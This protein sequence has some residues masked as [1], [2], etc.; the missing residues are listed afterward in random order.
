MPTLTKES[1]LQ[2]AFFDY[3]FREDVGFVCIAHSEPHNKASFAQKFFEWPKD[4]N[5][6]VKLIREVRP[7]H[8]VWFCVNLL[9][10]RERKK[11][12]CM[13]TNLVWADLDT[14]DPEVVQPP[15]QCVILSSPS[16][17]QAIWRLNEYIDPAEAEQFSKILAYTYKQDGADPSGWDLTQLLRIPYTFNHKYSIGQIP[18]QVKLVQSYESLMPKALMDILPVPDNM[19]RSETADATEVPGNLPELEEILFKYGGRFLEYRFTD[20]YNYVPHK[21]DDWSAKLWH[22]I[23]VCLE[24]GLDVEEAFVVAKSSNV[25]KYERDKRPEVYLWKEVVKADIKQKEW[26]L[27][28]GKLETLSMPRFLGEGETGNI[29]FIEQYKDWATMTT[30]AV[31]EY[32]E[33]S[34]FMLLSTILAG[35]IRIE[36]LYGN[37]VPNLWGLL[38]G[39]S[40]L[41]RKT[42]AM[43]MAMDLVYDIDQDFVLATDGS[44]EGILTGLSTRPGQVSI[45]YKD[46]VS[47]FFD[48]INKKD[49]LAGMLEILTHM[50]DVPKIFSRRLRKENIV[51]S[52]PVFLF[53]GGGVR[54]KVYSVVNDEYVLSGFLPRFLIVTGETDMGRIRPTGPPVAGAI[55]K[56]DNVRSS[57]FDIYE[58]YM[59][60]ESM[61]IA[62]Q[63][64]VVPSTVQAQLTDKA[65]IKYQAIENTILESA[66]TS[67]MP[68]LAL[69]TFER[70]SRSLLKMAALVAA[71][72]QEP[73]EGTIQV[74]EQ[75]IIGAAVYIQK[76]GKYSVD[77]I[78]N[79]GRTTDEK[80]ATKDYGYD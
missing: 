48:S 59:R 29:G 60:R 33:L 20:A 26:S 54:D 66:Q 41:T 63:E 40:T 1:Q 9:K 62:G 43:R 74:N 12:F 75:D 61:V 76:W 70:L 30:D 35:S 44:A 24:M 67:E 50:Y 5:K 72:R 19:I 38:L 13:P 73:K 42:T 15:P 37:M 4:K 3:L 79:A 51:V 45:F 21:G 11:E 47:G 2:L 64:V 7:D 22:L 71:T 6:L 36:T 46:E 32:H 18:P 80:E 65:W 68:M 52:N 16:K 23:N 31:E 56:R 10:K 25:N 58:Q 77:L 53:F 78:N 27:K 49:Y 39:D 57:L 14:C 8:N 17:Y 34:A 69:P 28:F 55:E